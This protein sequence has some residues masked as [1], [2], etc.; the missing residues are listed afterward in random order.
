MISS[1]SIIDRN[2]EIVV[3]R[4]YRRDF[5]RNALDD[6]RIGVIAAKETTSPID[7]INGSSF[8]HYYHDEL[9]YVASTRQNS[10]AGTIFSF[11]S[12]LPDLFKSV[13]DMENTG[14]AAIKAKSAEILEI[15]DEMIDCGYIQNTDPEAIRLLTQRKPKTQAVQTAQVAVTMTVTG[16]ISWRQPGIVYRQNEIFV[17]VLESVSLLCSASGKILDSSVNGKII[18][19]SMLSGMPE[20]KIGFNDKITA[21]NGPVSPTAQR[22]GMR[23]EVDDMVFHQCVR[24]TNFA[25]DRAISFIPPDG[26]FELLR[27]RKTDSVGV[28]FTITPMVRDVAAN[29]IEIRINVASTYEAKLSANPLILKIPMPENT[30]EVSV[31]SQTGKAKYVPEENAVLWRMSAFPGRSSADIIVRVRCLSATS[32]ASPATKIIDPI[33]VEFMIPMFS[34]SG[35]ALQ[36]LKVVEKSGYIP[37]KWLRYRTESGKFEIRMV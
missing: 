35:L 3:M 1:V 16:D 37:S 19:K 26:E 29:K 24:L 23:I 10:G 36:Y 14:P 27:Y 5:D 18:M 4:S 13:L 6:Y 31:D 11:L 30:A 12:K 22:S 21:G 34:S 33:S 2:G 8:L 25:N 15:L 17:D 7:L 28:P 32:K 20:C 9:Y